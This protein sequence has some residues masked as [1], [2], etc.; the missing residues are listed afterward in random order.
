MTGSNRTPARWEIAQVIASNMGVSII[1]RDMGETTI[2][3]FS[4]S[5]V[6]GGAHKTCLVRVVAPNLVSMSANPGEFNLVAGSQDFRKVGASFV[7]DEN[8]TITIVTGLE[9][10]SEDPSI[11]DAYMT[12]GRYANIRGYKEG[13]TRIAATYKGPGTN[14]KTLA[15]TVIVNVFPDSR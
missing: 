8:Y 6:W 1:P 10:T 11:A 14:G 15:D 13:T 2:H 3:A 9:W 4:G 7:D 5:G 12:Y